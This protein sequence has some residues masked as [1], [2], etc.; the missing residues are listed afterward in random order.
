MA[1]EGLSIPD[2][3]TLLYAVFITPKGPWW[4]GEMDDI[5]DQESDEGLSVQLENMIEQFEDGAN[6]INL[7]ASLAKRRSRLGF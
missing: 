1:G 3:T 5:S 2:I 4:Q 7:T 6:D